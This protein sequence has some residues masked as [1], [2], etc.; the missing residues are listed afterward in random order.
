MAL[1]DGYGRRLEHD[2][3]TKP[4]LICRLFYDDDIDVVH[5]SN[6]EFVDTEKNNHR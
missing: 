6:A 2:A 5:V 4:V 1:L 3:I